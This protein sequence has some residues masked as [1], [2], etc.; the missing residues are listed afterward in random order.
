MG[1][2]NTIS[3]LPVEIESYE[4]EGLER[5][6]SSD[7]TRMSTLIHLHGGGQTGSGEDVTYDALDHVAL[8]DAGPTL[9][10]SGRRTLGELCAMLGDLNLFPS[11]PERPVSRRYRRWAFESAALD[12]ALL[13]DG[14]SFAE[15][16]DREPRPVRYVVSL[17]LGDPP[18]FEPV[19]RRLERYP[20]LQ[21]KLDPTNDWDGPLIERMAATGSVVT[22]D[23]K[24]HYKGTIVDVE[25]DPELYRQL[26]EAFPDAWIEDPDVN[27]QTR[28]ILEPH[29]DRVTWDAPVHEVADIVN[30][31]W[32]PRM[33][34][35]KPSRA[36]TLQ[37][38]IE[39]YEHC[40]AHGI[41]IYG[42]GQFE[43]GVGRGHIQYLAS[44]FHPDTP[45]D[46]SPAGF[47][48]ADVPP[49]LPVSP[50]EPSVAPTGFRWT[51]DAGG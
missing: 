30:A 4:L 25:T 37:T 17:R 27:E 45:N 39:T 35:I 49:G 21:F 42:G 26:V 46:V 3:E 18:A 44:L 6:V 15:L 1:L 29:A 10:L 38:L 11:E 43:L 19:G 23:L 16:I 40:E 47:H 20:D 12:L 33:I 24:G 14:R 22:L 50:L 7:F 8:Q 41:A 28:P 31:P 36:G 13:Q 34:N 32:K 5:E 51:G 9:E 48:T 2:W